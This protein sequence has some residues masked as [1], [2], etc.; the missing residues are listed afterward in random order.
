MESGPPDVLGW[1]RML[2]DDF[3]PLLAQFILADAMPPTTFNLGIFSW[4]PTIQLNVLLRR[5]PQ[6]GG[7]QQIRQRS[8]L[9]AGERFDEDC[10]LWDEAGNL[11]VQ[12][13]QLAGYRVPPS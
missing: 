2:L 3:D 6:A 1:A 10:W 5:V 11:T 4:A 13:R 9:V 12:A 7:W 8:M